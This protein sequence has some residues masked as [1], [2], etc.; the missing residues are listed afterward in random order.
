[1][2]FTGKLCRNLD[3]WT[4]NDNSRYIYRKVPTIIFLQKILGFKKSEFLTNTV[5]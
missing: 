4:N 2:A 5:L 1:M 3:S